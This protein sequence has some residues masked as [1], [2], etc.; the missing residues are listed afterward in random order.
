MT[1][2]T[3]STGSEL[4]RRVTAVELTEEDLAR[5]HL[6]DGEPLNGWVNASGLPGG[7]I[8]GSL[9][10]VAREMGLWIEGQRNAAM[11]RSSM[12]D[13][14]AYAAPDN[15]FKQMEI[16]RNAVANDDI[17]GGAADVT[18]GLIFD[19]LK[20]E[21]VN[22][23][24]ADIFNQIGDDLG[25]DALAR[26]IHR[27]LFTYSTAVVGEWW[28][29]REYRVQGVTRPPRLKVTGQ[30]NYLTGEIDAMVT[31]M[32]DNSQ[33]TF[34][35][36][37]GGGDKASQKRGR[38]R[39]KTYDVYCPTA[40]TFLDPLKVVPV[41]ML[42]FGQEQLAWYCSKEEMVTWDRIR[43][44]E[45]VDAIM[46][47]FFVG[48]YVPSTLEKAELAALGVDPNRLM[49]LNPDRVWR[50]NR[51]KS[52]YMRFPDVRLKRCFRLLDLKQ[53]LM[54]AD[55]VVLIGAAN[56]ILLIKKG[57]DKTPGQ[58][59]E[60]DNLKNN[61]KVLARLPV[62]VA[63]HR[64][65]IEIITPKQDVTLM[66]DK[67]DLIDRRLLASCLGS[68]QVAAQGQRAENSITIAR[69]VGRLLESQRA[70][71]RR[72]LVQRIARAVVMEP[73]NAGRFSAVPNL[74]FVPPH[75]QLDND[76]AITQ[77]ILQLRQMNELSRD[78]TLEYF[79][80]DQAIEAQRR[81]D[82]EDLYDDIFHTQV[83][84]N[85]PNPT[86]SGG[87]GAAPGGGAPAVT[88]AA[89]GRKGGRPKGGG[90]SPAS[91]AGSVKPRT[92]SGAPST[93]SST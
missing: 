77:S 64:L 63:D 43:E 70:D 31:D 56:Y 3:V 36:G 9:D 14:Y 1:V 50:I 75:I 10:V 17:V 67:Y 12:F 59:P 68:L 28:G 73:R 37:A 44:G 19:G 29:R 76:A 39:R 79:G 61:M 81:E 24:D 38:A 58:Q 84:F 69:A 7:V 23:D 91:V 45:V 2:T 11:N 53:Q 13:R 72:M 40:L 54:E 16:A 26:K 62:I 35:S 48:K 27:E 52:D 83:P 88:P 78:S 85:S 42:M 57:D 55:R 32:T 90:K 93:G 21:S 49:L 30:D 80:F 65:N 89:S 25:M 20:W 34:G 6:P 60:I 15:P 92:P 5:G 22:A 74:Q 46:T 51:T 8:R 71:I 33:V 41:G 86:L 66:H 47:E 4:A 82:E 87:S 18:E